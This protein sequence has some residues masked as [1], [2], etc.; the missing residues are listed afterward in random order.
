[1]NA[2]NI[3]TLREA[4]THSTSWSNAIAKMTKGDTNFP[5]T[6]KHMG[7]DGKCTCKISPY[8]ARTNTRRRRGKKGGKGK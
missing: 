1:M 8:R 5:I 7:L 2:C 4:L 6:D 3:N